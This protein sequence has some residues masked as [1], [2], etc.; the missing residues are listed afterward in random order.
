MVIK[1]EM[2][3]VFYADLNKSQ[4][5]GYNNFFIGLLSDFISF[6]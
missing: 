1:S 6:R 5:S 2:A 3:D 4:E